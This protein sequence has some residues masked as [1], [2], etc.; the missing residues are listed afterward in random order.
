MATVSYTQDGV[1]Y[2]REIFSSHPD[3]A[4]VVHL[5]ADRKGALS[6]KASLTRPERYETRV[7]SG[8]LLMSGA[9]DDGKGGEGLRYGARLKAVAKGG[10]VGFSKDGIQVSRADDVVLILTA[11]TSHKLDYPDYQG[12]DPLATSSEQLAR[13]SSRPYARLLKRHVDDFRRLSGK[14]R[15]RLAADAADTVPTDVRLKGRKDLQDDLRLQ[16]IYFQYGRYLLISSSREGSLPANLQGLWANKIQ[17]PWNCD[18]HTDINVQMNY[19]P[20]DMT[21]L[22]ECT[23][24]LIELIGSLVAPGEGP[25]RS[26][27]TPAAGASIL[28]PTSGAS[29]PRASIRAGACTSAP[30]DGCAS[31]SGTITSIRSTGVTWKESTRS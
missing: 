6:F 9:M 13:A 16:E 27:T 20:A 29:P 3:R 26:N 1:R 5:A 4:L 10:R 14:V 25:R 28:S 2:R 15:L 11:S 8:D 7:E 19:W 21:G 31:I 22:A 24:P 12:S 17:N 23:G 18:Y 30:G